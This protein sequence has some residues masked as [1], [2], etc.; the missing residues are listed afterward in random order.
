MRAERA[1]ALCALVV[2]LAARSA[3]AGDA[4]VSTENEAAFRSGLEQYAH[5]NN[6]GAI[7]TW[8]SLLATLGEE[9]G[10]KVLYNLGLAYQAMGDVTHAIERYRAFVDQA[11]QRIDPFKAAEPVSDRV[12]D[13]QSR[14]D[15]LRHS[16]GA[17]Y[18][19]PPTRGGLVLTRIGTGEPRAAGYVVWVAPGRHDLEIFVGTDHVKK[20]RVEV[21][22]G[23]ATDVDT[24]PPAPPAVEARVAGPQDSATPPPPASSTWIWIG[25][26]A[27]AVSLAAPMTFYALASG[28]HNRAEALGPGHSRYADERSS[29]DTLRTLQYVSYA[30]P[31]AFALATVGYVLFRPTAKT[32]VAAFASPHALGFRG[33]F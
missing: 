17:I 32:A 10:W 19:R 7:A 2:V 28:A 15:Q 20:M 3:A 25:V 33:R 30:L 1:A 26:G 6:V 5:G 16:H 27:T 24:T 12:T 8:E 29:F 11:A 4:T 14:L 22:A 23:G 13:A 18:V 21:V 31:A 9:R